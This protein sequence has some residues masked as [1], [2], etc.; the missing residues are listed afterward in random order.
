VEDVRV[1][2]G[3]RIRQ[4]R[5][6]LRLSQEELAHRARIHTTY[7]SDVERGT[8]NIAIVNITKIAFALNLS[9]SELFSDF[10]IK[11]NPAGKVKNRSKPR[12]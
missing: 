7:L 10:K 4:L 2:L 3:R 1:V 5:E 8:R 12:D 11:M 6:A 9:L